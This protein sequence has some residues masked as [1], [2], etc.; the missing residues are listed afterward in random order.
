LESTQVKWDKIAETDWFYITSLE[1]NVELIETLIGFANEHSIK[2]AFNP[3]NRELS[4]SPRLIPLLSHLDFLLLNRTE[5]ETLAGIELNQSKYWEKLLSF[6]A[7]TTAVTD[8]RNGAYVLTSAEKLYSPIINT[9]TVDETGAGDA[10]GS[11]LIGGLIHHLSLSDSLFWG[12]KNS[13]SIV[14]SLGAKSGLLNLEEIK[15]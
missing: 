10:F 4:Q 1:G 2:V 14:S 8:G 3:G 5:S 9:R 7:R 6:G 13:A 11:A 15:T 12:I